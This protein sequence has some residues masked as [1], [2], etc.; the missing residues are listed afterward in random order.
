M[1]TV[2]DNVLAITTLLRDRGMDFCVQK[3]AAEGFTIIVHPPTPRSSFV[4][5]TSSGPP[6][7]VVPCRLVIC[8]GSELVSVS[9][10]WERALITTIL[11]PI[12]FAAACAL[13]G[14]PYIL[15]AWQ[16]QSYFGFWLL[17]G[18]LTFF[19]AIMPAIFV[20]G[21]VK[22]ALTAWRHFRKI[23]PLLLKSGK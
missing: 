19:G 20:G 6:S 17:L 16:S 1:G 2:E 18:G 15:R 9:V 7:F 11:M 8:G 5:L 3:Q 14:I 12:L 4:S 21:I 22:Q 10:R 23:A 13:V